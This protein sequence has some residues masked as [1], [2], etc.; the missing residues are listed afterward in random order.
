M[1]SVAPDSAAEV[2]QVPRRRGCR[3]PIG[4]VVAA[5][6]ADRLIKARA[7]THLK[8]GNVRERAAA[9]TGRPVPSVLRWLS[10]KE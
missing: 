8:D 1:L 7:V 4:E 6:E 10:A 9:E 3:L 5:R 2:E